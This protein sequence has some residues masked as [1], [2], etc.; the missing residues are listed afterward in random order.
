MASMEKELADVA[1]KDVSTRLKRG[2]RQW[3]NKPTTQKDAPNVCRT[4][5]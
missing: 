3:L 5:L 4:L 2:P 1:G